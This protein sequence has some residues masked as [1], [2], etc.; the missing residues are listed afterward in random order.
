MSNNSPSIEK[1]EKN[2]SSLPSF[3]NKREFIWYALVRIHQTRRYWL[4]AVL[5]LVVTFGFFINLFTGYNIL[6]A[7]YSLIP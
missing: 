4:L 5:A 1:S 7:I 3:R 2:D 6:P